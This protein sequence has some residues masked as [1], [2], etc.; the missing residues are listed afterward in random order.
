[1]VILHG[2]PKFIGDHAGVLA[3]IFLLGIQNLQPVG[4]WLQGQWPRSPPRTHDLR[5]TS[6]FL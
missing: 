6:P 5:L 4:A 1:M 3:R 2:L